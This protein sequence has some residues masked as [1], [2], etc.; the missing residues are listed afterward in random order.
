M[1]ACVQTP[2]VIICFFLPLLS[3]DGTNQYVTGKELPPTN[4]GIYTAG[5]QCC[6]ILIGV[7]DMTSGLPLAGIVS[8]PFYEKRANDWLG[9]CVWGVSHFRVHVTGEF[10]HCGYVKPLCHSWGT[11]LEGEPPTLDNNNDIIVISGSESNELISQIQSA[12]YQVLP[13]KGAGYKQLCVIDRR[14]VA[15]IR[16]GSTYKWDTCAPHA[17]LRA[18]GGEM[19]A[20]G[21]VWQSQ[22]LSNESVVKYARP[23]NETLSGGQV[24][25]NSTGVFAYLHSSTAQRLLQLTSQ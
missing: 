6:T 11:V 14:A 7:F 3:I 18:R 17:I 21:V 22:K 13:V 5:L 15:F 2:G 8:Q 1:G 16:D 24:W 23:D 12:G 4:G 25:K 10:R 19:M 20:F 9:R